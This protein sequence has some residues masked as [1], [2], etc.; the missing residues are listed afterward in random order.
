MAEALV[1]DGGAAWRF[2][3]IPDDMVNPDVTQRDQF[4]NDALELVEA[5]VREAI[6]NSTDQPNHQGPVRLRFAIRSLDSAEAAQLGELLSP[7]RRHGEACKLDVKVLDTPNPRVL[8]VEDFNT[9][10]LAGSVDSHDEGQFAGFWRRHG[11]SSK[12]S[13]KAGSH[14]LGKLVFSA[15]SA[16][17]AVF[18]HTIRADGLSLLMGQ[19]ILNN[20]KLDG[21]RLPAHGFWTPTHERGRIQLPTDDPDVIQRLGALFGFSRRDETGLSIAVPYVASEINEQDLTV[22]VVRNYFFPILA[23]DLIVEVGGLVISR[24]TF[25]EVELQVPGLKQDDH[26]RLNFVRSLLPP[27]ESAPE[28]VLDSSFAGRRLGTDPLPADVLSKMQDAW[29]AG[30]MVSLRVPITIKP[31][32]DADVETWFDLYLTKK[33]DDASAWAL[34]ARNSLVVPGESRKSFSEPAFGALIARDPSICAILRDAEDPAHTQWNA[35]EKLK[36]NWRYGEATVR[37]IRLSLKALYRQLTAELRE[38]HE[39]LLLD[40]LSVR[41]PEKQQ[42]RRV[43]TPPKPHIPVPQRPR[44]F[45]EEKVDGGFRIGA[46]PGAVDREMPVRIRIRVAYDVL[47]GNPFK[48]HSEHD[49]SFRKKSLSVNGKGAK[50]VETE[51][52]AFVLECNDPDFFVEVTGFDPNRDLI[53]EPRV[54]EA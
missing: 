1:A 28:N 27:L 25:R 51:H 44:F 40:F 36:K 11:G 43:R 34:F 30:R 10:G 9:T 47:S 53:V 50:V 4:N 15:S 37:D 13:S 21:V 23:G 48:L 8:V 54:S 42:G 5:L 38:Q 35:K 19:A 14:G 24:D 33:P 45:R 39:D 6:Q 41:H 16:L 20:H 52:S 29:S 49:F 2:S 46:G 3:P 7:L 32:R 22:A 26:Y 31:K 18:G 17:G 12:D